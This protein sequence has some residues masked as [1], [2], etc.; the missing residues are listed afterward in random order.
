MTTTITRCANGA[1][2]CTQESEWVATWLDYGLSARVLVC[3]TH[4]D[5]LTYALHVANPMSCTM[6]RIE[7]GASLGDLSTPEHLAD[8][9]RLWGLAAKQEHLDG[10]RERARRLIGGAKVLAGRGWR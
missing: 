8:I 3:G 10:K 7:G 1:G 2:H 4:I 5:V 9:A 6:T